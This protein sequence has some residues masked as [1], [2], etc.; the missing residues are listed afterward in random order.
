MKK[1]RCSAL[2]VCIRAGSSVLDE[3]CGAFCPKF[4][5][6]EGAGRNPPSFFFF[7]AQTPET[8]TLSDPILGKRSG[9]F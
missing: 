6:R 7:R 3:L 2:G 9:G 1:S 4:V 5:A 8:A